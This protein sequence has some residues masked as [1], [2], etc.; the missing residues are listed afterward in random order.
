M[1]AQYSGGVVG[2]LNHLVCIEQVQKQAL[3]SK[4]DEEIHGEKKKV[5][6][7]GQ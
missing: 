1:H 6:V 7:L 3:L 5:F 4:Y 2:H